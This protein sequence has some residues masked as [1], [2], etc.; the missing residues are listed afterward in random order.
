M[1]VLLHAD[2]WVEGASNAGA[3]W[4]D[5]DEL[6]GAVRPAAE[7]LSWWIDGLWAL[8]EGGQVFLERGGSADQL[9]QSDGCELPAGCGDIAGA[10]S[11]QQFLSFAA[12]THQVIDGLFVGVDASRT[13]PQ[14][15]SSPFASGSEHLSPDCD[16]YRAFPVVLA[17]F[18]STWWRVF[19][20]DDS[21]TPAIEIAV[22]QA[23]VLAR[24]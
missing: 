3:R 13:A 1:A 10:M 8:A 23:R 12:F 9:V 5:L 24:W 19:V 22:P 20:R 17:A 7:P 15:P 18:D 11:F 6:L 21:L 16:W 2:L 4:F 14:P